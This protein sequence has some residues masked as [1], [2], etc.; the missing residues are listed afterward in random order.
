MKTKFI[1]N[2]FNVTTVIV[3]VFCVL[4]IL[5]S[6][7]LIPSAIKN[8]AENSG[9]KRATLILLYAETRFHFSVCDNISEQA[10]TAIID[11]HVIS[12]TQKQSTLREW[13]KRDLCFVSMDMSLWSRLAES[14]RNSNS[15]QDDIKNDE[16]L[17]KSIAFLLLCNK[18]NR[19]YYCTFGGEVGCSEDT[20]MLDLRK[21][22]FRLIYSPW[23]NP[24]A[25]EDALE[26][27]P[28]SS[29]TNDR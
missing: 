3:I 28:A 6:I 12:H 1:K 14:M 8:N 15:F 27:V 11:K 5:F 2:F 9:K 26:S 22:N 17:S 19:F 24:P 23:W 13:F 16:I 29:S 25:S 18:G 7:S 20:S 4:W 10:L 21:W